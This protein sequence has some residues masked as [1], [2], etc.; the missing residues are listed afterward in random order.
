MNCSVCCLMS[1]VTN[2][3]TQIG[4]DAMSPSRTAASR[5]CPSTMKPGFSSSRKR[6]GQRESRECRLERTQKRTALRSEAQ[7]RLENRRLPLPHSVPSATRSRDT[8]GSLR[9]ATEPQVADSLGVQC[10]SGGSAKLSQ[11]LESV[12]HP[13]R[14]CRAVVQ[15]TDALRSPAQRNTPRSSTIIP[16]SRQTPSA[17][18]SRSIT[19]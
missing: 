9:C 17:E 6:G 18:S 1:F 19:R 8:C 12:C 7:I 3:V 2:A 15:A 14:R 13:Q 11:T 5:C 4:N 16:P 10:R